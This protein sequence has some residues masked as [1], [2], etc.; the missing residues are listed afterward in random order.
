MAESIEMSPLNQPI[1]RLD[2]R[3]VSVD[4]DEE[5]IHSLPKAGSHHSDDHQAVVLED[6]VYLVIVKVVSESE[7]LFDMQLEIDIK[8]PNGYLS[9]VEYPLLIFYGVMCIVYLSYAVYW[10][11]VSAMRWRDL[12]RIQFWVGGVILLG[13]IEKAVFY[14]EHTSVNTYGRSTRGVVLVAELISCLKRTLAR[15]LV[16]IVSLGFGIVKPRLGS[17]FHRVVSVGLLY[18]ILSAGESTIRVYRPKNDPTNQTSLAGIPL[19]LLDS[20]ICWWVFSALVQ[21]TR[22]LRLRRNSVKLS[23]YTHFTNTLVIAVI[24]KQK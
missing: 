22:T 11:I 18:F 8:G 16:V 2:K 13:M 6:G 20:A 4:E 23:L 10:S 19:A 9:A 5:T 17:V 21:T 12:L 3:S 1:V 7:K 24:G 15:M 14:A